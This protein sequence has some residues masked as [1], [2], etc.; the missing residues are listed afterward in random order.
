[1][2]SRTR[3]APCCEVLQ[4]NKFLF[5][6]PLSLWYFIMEALFNITSNSLHSIK[7]YNYSISSSSWLYFSIYFYNV[8]VFLLSLN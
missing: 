6:K 3:L 7:L 8:Y 1:M 5:C 2:P 4:E